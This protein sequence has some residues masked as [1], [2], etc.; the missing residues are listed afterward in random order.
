MSFATALVTGASGFI[1]RALTARLLETGRRVIAAGREGSALPAADRS[2]RLAFPDPEAVRQALARERV[3]IVF[4]CAAYGVNPADRDPAAMHAA[5]VA[6][7]GAWVEAAAALGARAFVHLGSCAEYG[8]VSDERPIGEDRPLLATDLYGTSKAEGG[9]RSAETAARLRIPFVWVRPFGV[10]GPGEAAHR[11]LPYLHARLR[12]GA[13]VDLTPGRQMRDYLYIDDAVAGLIAAGDAALKGQGGPYNLCSGRAVTI[14]AVAEEAAC[15]MQ[16]PLD[17]L[18]FGARDY[19]P[20]EPM[21][22]VGDPARLA[23]ASG[24][25][26]AIGVEDGIARMMLALDRRVARPADARRRGAQA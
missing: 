8:V 5:N 13:R 25:R 26:A 17:R 18:A 12:T 24:F 3:E 22:M 4:H 15:A 21:W 10:F 16:V 14:R 11:L 9:L 19:R 7:V 1:G 2:L 6:A 20:G 23:A